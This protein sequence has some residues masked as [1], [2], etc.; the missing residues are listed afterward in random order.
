MIAYYP[1]N[2]WTI[3]SIIISIMLIAGLGFLCIQKMSTSQKKNDSITFFIFLLICG[4]LMIP[5]IWGINH[6]S[7]RLELVKN[8]PYWEKT[9]ARVVETPEWKG[10]ISWRPGGEYSCIQENQNDGSCMKVSQTI[11]YYL[12]NDDVAITGQISGSY[13]YKL[14][15][16]DL[17]TIK[18][19]PTIHII[20]L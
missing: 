1:T 2:E 18:V 12:H 7:G 15:I 17:I 11:S 16:D 9:V 6:N 20:S 14:E 5:T 3:I 19:D 4:G 8:V 10:L 13:E